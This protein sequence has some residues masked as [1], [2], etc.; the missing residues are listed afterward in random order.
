MATGRIQPVTRVVIS[1]EVAG[2]IVELPVKEGQ[3]VK[4]GD[5]LVKIK[6][7]NYLARLDLARASHN[8]SLAS[9]KL[10]KANLEK[11][12]ADFKRTE[13]LY[14]DK[15]ISEEQFLS[16]KNALQVSEAS[17]QNSIHSVEQAQASLDQ[18]NEELA[19]TDILAP[20]E[21]TVVQLRSEKG[22]RVVGTSMM[23]GTEIMTI[24]QLD[25]MEARVE[26]G[27]IDV[28]M[29]KVGQNVRL[30]ADAF[31]DDEFSGEVTEIANASNNA[32]MSGSGSA[33]ASSSSAT[34]FQVKIRVKEKEAFRP[35]MSV[36]AYIETRSKTNVLAVPF[37]SVAAR[38][39]KKSDDEKENGE[40]NSKKKGDKKKRTREIVFLVDGDRVKMQ[41]VKRGISD[42]DY[43]EI[44]EGLEEGQEVV[45]GSYSAISRDLKEN[46][47][48]KK[49]E[50]SED[51]K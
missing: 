11:A 33:S 39:A 34:K 37:Q 8:G 14:R 20:I 6:Q 13:G 25:Q 1:P 49:G 40:N 31:R 17:Y 46:S 10:S 18:A 51:K 24:A 15:L 7:D 36:T 29:I 12:K 3:L 41:D 35:G 48:V 4:A 22:E 38:A 44:E 50:S 45:S 9:Q 32:A 27:E 42:D 19:K 43:I 16:G 30:E 2:E 26:V 28:V 5:P 21:G 23:S 47:L